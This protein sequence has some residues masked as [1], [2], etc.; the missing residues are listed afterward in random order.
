MN[1]DKSATV[2]LANIQRKI[3]KMSFVQ[4]RNKYPFKILFK[5]ISL[6][7]NLYLI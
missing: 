5:I 3:R 7:I 6:K 1:I 2:F 4:C